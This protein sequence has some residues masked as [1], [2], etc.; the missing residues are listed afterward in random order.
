MRTIE[1]SS[2]SEFAEQVLSA[3]KKYDGIGR[4][5]SHR[6]IVNCHGQ[7]LAECLEHGL[8]P[9]DFDC[10]GIV[11]TSIL[12]VLGVKNPNLSPL[13]HIEQ[14]ASFSEDCPPQQR[15]AGILIVQN[16]SSV[17]VVPDVAAK[18][19]LHCGFLLPDNRI[20]HA[21]SRTGC[22]QASWRNA[23]E[24]ANDTFVSPLTLAQRIMVD[25][26]S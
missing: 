3:A 21:S 11:L 2:E 17:D 23:N 5:V 26:H 10:T 12:D 1:T 19:P 13:R 9:K 16:E 7:P 25:W 14:V 15:Y 24:G 4:F 18:H 20:F 8:G 6:A 22:V